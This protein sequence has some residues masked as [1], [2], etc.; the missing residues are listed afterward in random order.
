MVGTKN[1]DVKSTDRVPARPQRNGLLCKDANIKQ[2][3]TLVTIV[4]NMREGKVLDLT[5][6]NRNRDNGRQ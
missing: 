2:L 3:Q 1:I 6:Y 4:I 5:L